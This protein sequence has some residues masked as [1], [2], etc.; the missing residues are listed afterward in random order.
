[1][2]DPH[3]HRNPLVSLVLVPAG[4]LLMLAEEFIWKGLKA[5][6]ARIGELPAVARLESRIRALPPFGAAI[7]FLAPGAALLPVELA[8]VWIQA[9]GHVFLGLVLLIAAKLTTTALFARV[10]T[11]C[12]PTLMTVPWFVRLHGWISGAKA[13]AHAKLEASAGWRLARRAVQR[14]RLWA[15]RLATAIR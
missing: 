13:W 12:E 6:M 11:L 9:N 7:M 10:Y 2:T 1:M 5:L 14:A 15:M 8:A 3:R 4:V